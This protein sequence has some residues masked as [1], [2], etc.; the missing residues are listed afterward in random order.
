MSCVAFGL[1][2]LF[3]F[4]CL[5]AVSVSLAP[6]ALAQQ[7]KTLAILMPGA[8]GAV[9]TDFLIRNRGRISGAGLDTQVA[10]SAE[11]AASIARTEAAKGRKVVVVGMSQ[12]GNKAGQVVAAGAP[13]AGVVFVSAPLR[14]VAG[15]I[16]AP[17]KMPAALVVHHRQD[18]CQ[19][20]LP[21]GVGYFQKWGGGKVSVRWINTTGKEA[22]NPC[23]PRGAHGFYMQDGQAVS[24]II[25]FVRAR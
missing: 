24:A 22:P 4:L 18:G 15:A 10:T 20:T 5:L 13:L 19:R 7:G 3:V 16:G 23:G 21:E 12:G 25:E 17:A 9:S 1:R 11:Q 8:G 2:S 14:L 6:G